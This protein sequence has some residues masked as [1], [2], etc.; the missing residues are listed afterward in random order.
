MSYESSSVCQVS[1]FPTRLQAQLQQSFS[2]VAVLFHFSYFDQIRNDI[3][4]ERLSDAQLGDGQS[5][6]LV[7]TSTLSLNFNLITFLLNAQRSTP[8]K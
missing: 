1:N 8:R 2:T 5:N 4:R 6:F 7:A 3:N